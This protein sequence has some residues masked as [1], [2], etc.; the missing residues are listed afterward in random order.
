MLDKE[1]LTM[2]HD[3][4]DN[5]LD[6]LDRVEQQSTATFI[7]TGALTVA[8]LALKAKLEAGEE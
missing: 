6:A 1:A 4:V 5:A 7:A 2:A 3:D 8:Q